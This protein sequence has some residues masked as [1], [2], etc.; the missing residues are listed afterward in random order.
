MRAKAQKIAASIIHH[1]D[2]GNAEIHRCSD[3]IERIAVRALAALP[4]IP[5]PLQA[6]DPA[7]PTTP[8]DMFMDADVPCEVPDD[9]EFL[10]LLE[11]MRFEGA[12]DMAV[13]F[14]GELAATAAIYARSVAR[15]VDHLLGENTELLEDIKQV[16]LASDDRG[17]MDRVHQA[18]KAVNDTHVSHG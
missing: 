17:L 18:I 13:S 3:L 16:N 4:K 11:G 9:E 8:V 6:L 15:L 10:D 12:R 2:D 14:V 1:I 5:N 7:S